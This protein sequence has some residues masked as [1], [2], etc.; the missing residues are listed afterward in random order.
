MS[1]QTKRKVHAGD[2]PRSWTG[3]ASEF[4][5]IIAEIGKRTKARL[6]EGENDHLV[7]FLLQSSGFT[8]EPRI[9]PAL[10]AMEFV[11]AMNA[12]QRDPY[13]AG[14][15]PPPDCVPKN[16]LRRMD[17]FLQARPHVGRDERVSYFQ[18]LV[19]ALGKPYLVAAY[20][21][22]MRFLYEKE[23]SQ[24]LHHHSP[25]DLYRERGYAADT[26]L[27]ANFSVWTALSVLK[28]LEPALAIHRIL[29]VGPGLDLAP[30]T[31]MFDLFPP[32]SYQ[33]FAVADALLS[34]GI[35]GPD[36]L[37]VHCIDVNPLVVRFFEEFR[38]RPNKTL[39]LISGLRRDQLSSDF[40]EYHRNLG[41]KI[42]SES[43]LD[44]PEQ[45]D[46]HLAK[47]LTVRE[48]IARSVTAGEM[49]ILTERY[50]PSPAYDLVVAT[51]VLVYFNG[52]ELRLALANIHS[53]LRPGGY[54]VHNELRAEVESVGR[55]LALTPVQAR[56]I[57]MSADAAKPL[58]DSFVIQRRTD[59]NGRSLLRK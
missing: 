47:S 57:H 21:R 45:L 20:A 37:Q 1:A 56:T 55:A 25:A 3:S 41:Q 36:R 6:R 58:L 18:D 7:A 15:E 31:E 27:E 44:L 28:S 16:V 40:H 48:D 49:N 35:T 19:G 46:S 59:H 22:T 54:L 23:S 29:I 17:S 30:R 24:T 2:F 4:D 42:G 39:R 10:S 12:D 32:Q 52:E 38:R 13:L 5:H 51:N 53:M 50:D 33:P 34:L 11:R 9:E 8:G 43:A 14:G 26:Q